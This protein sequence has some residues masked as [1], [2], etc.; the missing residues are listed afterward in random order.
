[1]DGT[2]ID[3]LLNRAADE[4][5]VPGTVAMVGDRDGQ[6]YE[7]AF[8]VTSIEDSAPVAPDT[9]FWIASMTKALV[10]A[11]A[12]QQIEQGRL[13][14]EQPVADVMPEFGELQVLDGWDGD[15]PRLRPPAT[16][17]T[18]RQLLTHTSG[19]SYF[20]TNP[21]LLRWHTVTGT[22]DPV[23]GLLEMFKAPLVHDPGQVFEYGTSVDWLGRVIEAV[24]GTDLATCCEQN[25]FGP[26]GMP[27]T[28]FR[29]SDAQRDRLMALHTRTPDGGLALFPVE[30]PEEPEFWSGGGGCYSTA[31][32]Y[33]R[34]IRALLRGGELDGERILQAETVDLMFTDHLHGA[35]LPDVMESAMPE[36]SNPV[37]KLPVEQGFGLGLH[38]VSEDLPGMRRAGTGDWAG[39]A[40]CYYWIDRRTGV[41]ALALTQVLPF[42]DAKI[43]ETVMGFE[44]A[45]YAAV[46]S[47]AA[48]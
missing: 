43:I 28:T 26:L 11:A 44:L 33:M 12:L 24:T 27:D 39:L 30:L 32:D 5:V 1:M 17:A 31:G 45:V 25:I 35:P 46:G 38:V 2:G 22:P 14:L 48:A 3:G 40:N 21:E 34:F 7:G 19:L 37:P 10:S 42:F 18:I 13:E 47:P 9:T 36:F 15:T 20:F 41:G 8:G 23:S 29:P 4:R 6:I 16:Q